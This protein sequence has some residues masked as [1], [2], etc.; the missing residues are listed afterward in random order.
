[1][2]SSG[3]KPHAIGKHATKATHAVAIS[4]FTRLRGIEYVILLQAA[5][6][7]TAALSTEKYFQVTFE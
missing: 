4:H 5:K 7:Q 1:M 6:V 2:S 3:T